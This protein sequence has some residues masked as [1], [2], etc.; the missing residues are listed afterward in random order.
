MQPSR[1]APY[2]IRFG[3]ACTAALIPCTSWVSTVRILD[4]PIAS[5][6]RSGVATTRAISFD[7]R[8]DIDRW[9]W[10]TVIVSA[11]TCAIVKNDTSATYCQN[12]A[13]A[14]G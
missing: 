11:E 1:I 2:N 7:T 14:G 4:C 9:Q 3:T 12:T 13:G 5:M 8:S 10:Y 6:R